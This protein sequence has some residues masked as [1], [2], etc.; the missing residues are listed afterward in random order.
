MSKSAIIIGATSGIGKALAEVLAGQGYRLGLTGRRLPLLQEIK[1]SLAAE[2]FIEQMDVADVPE[3]EEKFKTL[4]EK[5]GPIDLVIISAGIGHLNS[6]LDPSLEIKTIETNV[7]G[8]VVIADVAFMHFQTQGKGHLVGISSIAALRGSA[9]APAY[10]A[11]KAFVSN[12][13]E[14]LRLKA[15][16]A[17]L[18]ITVTDV[19]PGFVDTPMTQGQSM[20]WVAPAEKAAVQIWQAIKAKKVCVYIT[21]RWRLIAWLMRIMPNWIYGKI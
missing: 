5:M 21:R 16:K 9:L 12:Y 20:F 1:E 19:R 2:V 7:S 6:K 3:T 4:I 17:N 11:S 8:F 14:G 18:D 13:M 10:S 15:L